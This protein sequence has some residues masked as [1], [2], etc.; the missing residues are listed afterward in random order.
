MPYATILG[1]LPTN[2]LLNECLEDRLV[3]DKG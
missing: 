1:T 2:K 3:S